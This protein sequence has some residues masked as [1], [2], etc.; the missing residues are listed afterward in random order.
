MIKFSVFRS[1]ELQSVNY[2]CLLYSL[3]KKALNYDDEKNV[4][5]NFSIN[6]EKNKYYNIIRSLERGKNKIIFSIIASLEMNIFIEILKHF[7]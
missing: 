2:Q 4:S 1:F 5:F 7:I 3:S 6:V